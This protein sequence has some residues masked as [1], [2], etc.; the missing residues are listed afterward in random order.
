MT[1][2]S[3]ENV[4]SESGLTFIEQL[5]AIAVEECQTVNRPYL[6]GVSETDNVAILLRPHCKMWKCK[7]CA[8]R[9]ARRWIARIINHVNKFEAANWQFITITAHEKWRGMDS[10]VKNIRQ[11]WKKLYN[12]LLRRFGQFFYLKVWEAH[13]DG[14][15]HLHLLVSLK[16]KKTFLKKHARQ[17]GMGYQVDVQGMR[18]AGRAAGYVAKYFL[19]SEIV[20]TYP[21]GLRRIEASRNWTKLPELKAETLLKWFIQQTRDGQINRAQ[22]FYDR[23]FEIID[24][25]KHEG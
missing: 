20:G 17:C 21:H 18:N 2:R 9:N 13:K 25:L 1:Y 24:N 6:V 14:S 19:K 7:T 23:G 8:A 3:D 15:M 5:H 12:R 16:L 10:S 11:G 4:R 22:T